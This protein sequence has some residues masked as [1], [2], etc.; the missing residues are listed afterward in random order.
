MDYQTLMNK[1]P[2]LFE[3]T[4]SIIKVITDL[5]RI[6]EWQ[7]KKRGQ[8]SANERPLQWA[9]IGV[10]LD[11]PYIVVLRDLVEFPGGQLGGYFRV[12]NRADLNGGQ[13]AVVLGEMDGKILLLKLFRHPVRSWSFEFPRGFGEPGISAEQQAKNEIQEEVGGVVAELVDLGLYYSN[14]G[15]EGNKVK[16]FYAKIESVGKPEEKEGIESIL[17]VSSSELEIMIA[18]AIITDGFTIAAYTRAKLRGLFV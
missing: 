11:D 16:L 18:R 6:G 9:D 15:L 7:E 10:V 13:G 2:E 8:L 17:W 1:H 12:L 14:T 3:N 4:D 5:K